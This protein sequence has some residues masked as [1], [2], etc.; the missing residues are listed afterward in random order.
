VTVTA[1]PTLKHVQMT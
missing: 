1:V